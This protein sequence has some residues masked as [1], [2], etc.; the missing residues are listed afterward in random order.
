MYL[1]TQTPHV[2]MEMIVPA[3]SVDPTKIA[4]QLELEQKPVCTA[5]SCSDHCPAAEMYGNLLHDRGHRA[6]IASAPAAE[7]PSCMLP[8]HAGHQASPRLTFWQSLYP[9]VSGPLTNAILSSATQTGR[10]GNPLLL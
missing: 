9:P 7:R 1:Y 8:L 6:L 10:G 5:S 4:V 2:M 3:T